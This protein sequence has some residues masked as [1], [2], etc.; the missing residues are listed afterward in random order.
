MY[1]YVCAHAYTCEHTCAHTNVS[2]FQLFHWLEPWGSK[3]KSMTLENYTPRNDV[4]F[5]RL[6]PGSDLYLLSCCPTSFPRVTMC[7][8]E[9]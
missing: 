3:E 7:S 2:C 5:G 8:C 6:P 4:I 1:V 9:Q